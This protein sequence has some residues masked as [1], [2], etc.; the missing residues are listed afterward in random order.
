MG[1]SRYTF[2][3]DAVPFLQLVLSGSMTMYAPYANQSFYTDIDVLR[4]IEYNAYPSF[5]LTGADSTALRDTASEEY[6]S[7]CFNDW[8]SMAVNIYNTIDQVLSN[9]AGE[10]MLAHCVL[11]EGVVQVQYPSGSV[12][13]NY[14]QQDVTVDGVAVGARQAVFVGA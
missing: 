7:T 10:Q 6:F 13:I 4:C 3:T 2:Q 9:V 5:L 11:Q 1:S 8:K 12:Y 14:T